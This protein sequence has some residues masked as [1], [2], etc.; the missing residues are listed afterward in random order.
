MGDHAIFEGFFSEGTEDRELF[1]TNGEHGS[2]C[3]P[4]ERRFAMGRGP[5]AMLGATARSWGKRKNY[6]GARWS[7][8]FWGP[9]GPGRKWRA[10]MG[11]SASIRNCFT[12]PKNWVVSSGRQVGRKR[13]RTRG[14]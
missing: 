14:S 4:D 1:F 12:G 7:S 13:R 3:T 5:L 10:R 11:S 2:T 8:F 9:L 6:A